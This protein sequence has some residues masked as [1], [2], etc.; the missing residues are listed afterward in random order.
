MP[1]PYLVSMD[2]DPGGPK[3]CTLDIV[4]G[5]PIAASEVPVLTMLLLPQMLLTGM[6]AVGSEEVNCTLLFLSHSPLDGGRITKSRK[7]NE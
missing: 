5:G 1:D 6:T 4:V 3:T 2:P 7:S